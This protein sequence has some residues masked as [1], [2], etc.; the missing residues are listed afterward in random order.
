MLS[1]LIPHPLIPDAACPVLQYAGDTLLF[2]C[3]SPCAAIA[4]KQVLEDFTTATGLAIN[5]HKSTFVPLHLEA[6][7][8][9]RISS[10][11]GCPV[12]TFPQPYLGLPLSASKLHNVDFQPLIS[13]CDKYLSGWRGRLLSTGGR[14]ILTNVVL[15]LPVY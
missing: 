12:S 13:K 5:Y 8:T 7:Y 15:S 4:L 11:L 10:I 6:D 3:D 2:L 14:L 1:S 9:H